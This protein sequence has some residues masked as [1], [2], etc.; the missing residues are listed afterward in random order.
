MHPGP[1]QTHLTLLALA[2]ICAERIWALAARIITFFDRRALANKKIR[3]LEAK[4]AKCVPSRTRVKLPI[5]AG[6]PVPKKSKYFSPAHSTLALTAGKW[7]T[8]QFKIP[9]PQGRFRS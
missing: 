1:D 2:V 6:G 9:R 5:A 7:Q 4:R 8:R 3:A